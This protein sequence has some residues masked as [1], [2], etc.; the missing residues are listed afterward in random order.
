MTYRLLSGQ[1]LP[2]MEFETAWHLVLS[3]ISVNMASFFFSRKNEK[4]TF[5]RLQNTKLL[6]RSIGHETKNFLQISSIIGNFI[7]SAIK[8]KQI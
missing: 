1:F 3:F 8:E 2:V 7:T 6:G 4:H 5:A